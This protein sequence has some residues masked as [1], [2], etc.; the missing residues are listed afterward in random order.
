MF[1]EGI[2]D[3]ALDGCRG[4]TPPTPTNPTSSSNDSAAA[5]GSSQAAAAAV[6]H[7][8]Y[9]AVL[10]IG[11]PT[12]G[13]LVLDFLRRAE[14]ENKARLP[15]LV[16]YTVS[17][18]GVVCSGAG[19]QGLSPHLLVPEPSCV[20]QADMVPTPE[21]VSTVDQCRRMVTQTRSPTTFCSGRPRDSLVVLRAM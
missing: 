13:Q 7:V 4:R 15:V 18:W 17:C 5:S 10:T 1:K 12:A 2:L 19:M 16:Q 20:L 14:R 11:S 21:P 3:A 9:D 8:C 6:P